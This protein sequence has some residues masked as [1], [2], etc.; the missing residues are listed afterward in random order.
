LEYKVSQLNSSQRK[1]Q[2]LLDR[3]PRDVMESITKKQERNYE[4]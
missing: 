4:R 1:A 2:D 3:V